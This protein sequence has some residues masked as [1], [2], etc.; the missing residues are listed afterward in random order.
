MN[1]WKRDLNCL[2]SSHPCLAIPLSPPHTAR[3][4]SSKPLSE[5]LLLVS[6][7]FSQDL[8]FQTQKHFSP[9]VYWGWLLSI[10]LPDS[11]AMPATESYW[12][13]GGTKEMW[14]EPCVQG[15]DR[16]PLQGSNR[17]PDNFSGSQ[18]SSRAAMPQGKKLLGRTPVSPQPD[19]LALQSLRAHLCSCPHVLL[20]AT[21][22]QVP[23]SPMPPPPL[24][25]HSLCSGD[26]WL[27]NPSQAT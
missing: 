5:K 24:W 15:G 25:S 11:K 19:T 7:G 1:W 26:S 21:Y 9:L 6:E 20:S 12:W 13:D 23:N 22:L 16:C 14:N 17:A 3:D 10:S 8:S 27:K 2:L 4:T 18:T